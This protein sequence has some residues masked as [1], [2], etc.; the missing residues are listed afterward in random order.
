MKSLFVTSTSPNAGKTTLIIGLAKNLSNKKFGYMKP[1]G[2][3]IVYKKKRLWDYDAASIVKI[4]KLDEV[5]ENLSIGFD[6][7]KIMYMYNEEQ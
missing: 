5:P 4:F 7:S 3:R 2:E 1:F 6:H